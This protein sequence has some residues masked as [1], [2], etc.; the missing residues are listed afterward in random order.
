MGFEFRLG[1]VLYMLICKADW[2]PV[3]ILWLVDGNPC[4]M[5][6]KLL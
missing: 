3:R 6:T 5:E 4:K 2:E 1:A